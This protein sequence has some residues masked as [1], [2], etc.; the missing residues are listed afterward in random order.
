MLEF[1]LVW[2]KIIELEGEEFWQV[3][4]KG[5]NYKVSGNTLF[6]STTNYSI[7]RSQV[8]AAWKRM[9]VEKPSQLKDL[10]APS[11]LFALLTDTRITG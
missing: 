11:Y 6:L 2:Q 9:P 4:G 10:V 8:E 7:S 1:D 3:R 5:F